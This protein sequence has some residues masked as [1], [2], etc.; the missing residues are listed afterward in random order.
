MQIMAPAASFVATH[1][2]YASLAETE[3]AAMDESVAWMIVSSLNGAWITSSVAFMLLM[4]RKYMATFFSTQTGHAFCKNKFI[5]GET[6]EKKMI[7]HMRNKKLW[8]SIRDD[9]KAWT[10][11]N[12]ERWEEEKP[13]WFN[14]AWTSKVDD[15]MIPAASLRKMH[16]GSQRRKSSLGDVLGVGA[17]VAPIGGGDLQ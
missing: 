7:V 16:D 10:I 9:V 17:R 2:Y 13:K 5:N 1:V 14:D 15:D 3:G 6:D 11:E 8:K 12:W 4:K